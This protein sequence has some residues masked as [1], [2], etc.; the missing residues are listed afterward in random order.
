[1]K[2]REAIKLASIYM[3]GAVSAPA[4]FGVLNG[5]TPKPSIN[6]EPKFL[7]KDQGVAVAEI[8]ERIIPKTETPGAKDVGVP[9]FI[10]LMLKDCYPKLE[11]DIFTKG[12]D[13]LNQQAEE[14]FG[15]S[16]VECSE[17]EQYQLLSPL[18]KFVAKEAKKPRFIEQD[19]IFFSI[20]KELTLLGYFTSEV[21]ASEV[22][23][24]NPVPSK[25][26]GCVPWEEI[27]TPWATT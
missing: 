8:A 10:D 2:R 14:D 18:N 25:F 6:W 23:Q 27:G 13:L 15:N 4:I 17:E 12:L 1:M 20:M 7:T 11:Q 21:G 22:L 26:N 9:E 19:K 16:F 24:Y 3:G 5:C